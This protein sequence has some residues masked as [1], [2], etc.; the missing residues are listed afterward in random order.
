MYD[1]IPIYL[2]IITADLV[3]IVRAINDQI[4]SSDFVNY[5]VSIM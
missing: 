4:L 5:S 2:L 3:D 1:C